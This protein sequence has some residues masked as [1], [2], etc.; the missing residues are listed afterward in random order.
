LDERDNESK[1]FLDDYKSLTKM[2]SP[3]KNVIKIVDKNNEKKYQDKLIVS[4]NNSLTILD[5]NVEKREIIQS[6]N[7]N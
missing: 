4:K 6:K 3:V 2:K 1:K 5:D 7:I